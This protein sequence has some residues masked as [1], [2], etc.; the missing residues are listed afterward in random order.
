MGAPYDGAVVIV[1]GA[2][3][4]IGLELAKQ[5]APRAKAIALVARRVERLE[6]LATELRTSH[7]K[8]TVFVRKC[9]LTDLNDA[10]A[11]IDDTAK[12]LGPID[13]L[14]NN[15]GFGDV[16][17]FD[18][19]D[20]DKLSRMIQLNCTSLTYL[21]SRVIGGM[22]ERRRGGVLNIS[23][24]FGLEWMPGFAAYA[25]T[26]HYVTAFTEALRL[27]AK[28]FGV[29]VT[30]V[31]PGPV[32]TEF[33]A[34]AGNPTG[35]SVPGIVRIDAAH[36]ARSSLRGFA[37]G[38]AMVVPGLVMKLVMLLG[39]GSP[40]WIKRVLYSFAARWLRAREL[41]AARP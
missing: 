14:V 27:E 8:L 3:S 10:G 19:A 13:V 18:L 5:M 34:V 17:M 28:Q 22:Y 32:D 12:E 24:G 30:Q 31:C 25:G 20:R 9:D 36:C 6:E 29:T 41:E 33:E 7:P 15:A 11:M 16:G 23:S 4:G 37:S 21:T 35:E 2:S 26:K 38:R 40:R 39:A 1:T